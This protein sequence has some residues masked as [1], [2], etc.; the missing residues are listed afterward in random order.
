MSESR[1]HSGVD[2][3]EGGTENLKTHL[4]IHT[5]NT[6]AKPPRKDKENNESRRGLASVVPGETGE[7]RNWNY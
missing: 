2:V 5:V 7:S 1:A 3:T 6:D 4:K